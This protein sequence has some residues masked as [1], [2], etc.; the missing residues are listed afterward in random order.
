MNKLI[1][2][3]IRLKIPITFLLV[4]MAQI[5]SVQAQQ[6]SYHGRIVD[7]VS[8][9]G[10]VGPVDFRIQVLTGPTTDSCIMYEETQPKSLSNGVFVIGINNS[11]GVRTDPAPRYT[12]S[13][14]FSNK[15]PFG[16][17]NLASSRCSSGSVF[18]YTPG[19]ND[20]RRVRISFRDGTM[21]PGVWE[22]LPTQ[23]VAY[24]PAA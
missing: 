15:N 17:F 5:F 24:V 3:I 12:L 10:V 14:V 7:G 18:T 13:Q 22:P 19:M 8:N 9:V 21:A 4:L 16:S 6:L 23:T 1:T 11:T 20:G 2:T